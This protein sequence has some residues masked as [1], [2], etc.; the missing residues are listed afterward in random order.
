MSMIYRYL[1]G[2]LLVATVY[3][4]QQNFLI[5]EQ[6]ICLD[7]WDKIIHSPVFFQS[8]SISLTP[9]KFTISGEYS[10]DINDIFEASPNNDRNIYQDT[11]FQS[12]SGIC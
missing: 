11:R 10:M 8:H 2:L 12:K 1:A 5:G 3:T 6:S 9:G 4:T 7:I